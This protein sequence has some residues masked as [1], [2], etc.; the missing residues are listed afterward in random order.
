MPTDKPQIVANDRL[1]DAN[2]HLTLTA[3][4]AQQR[5]EELAQRNEDQNKIVLEKRAM[6]RELV[7]QLTVFE[8]RERKRLAAELHDYLAQMLVLG[9]LKIGQARHKMS[10]IDLLKAPVIEE[11]DDILDK[12][13]VYTRTLI[14]ELSPPVLHEL[15]LPPAL[16]WLAEQMHPHN[17]TV[18]VQC[19]Q[20]TVPLSE[21]QAILLYQ[22]VRELL[23]NV[24]KHAKTSHATVSLVVEGSDQLLLTV[25]DGGCGFNIGSAEAKSAGEHFGLLSVNERMEAMGGWLKVDSV[26]GRGTTIILGLPLKPPSNLENTR[27][28]SALAR[29]EPR[30]T[31]IRKAPG[32]RSVLLADDHALV[33]QG[34]R[35]ILDG[36][37]DFCVIGEAGNGLEAVTM[38]I[39]LKPDVV[40]MDINMPGMDGIQATQQIKAAQPTTV[41]VGLSVNQSTQVIQAMT[42]AGA[43][44]VVSKDAVPEL[45]HK[46]L[47]MT[48]P[49]FIGPSDNPIQSELPYS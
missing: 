14:A 11:L 1:R 29:L 4:E 19:S 7:S 34:L 12:A 47:T 8:Q 40:L 41:V 42:E 16:K 26:P 38:A 44:G 9:R 6:L 15:G 24:A 37:P 43:S 10:S 17:L 27:A 18:E 39:G 46:V 25:Q 20:Q 22:S 3:L 48:P 32:V 13:L 49:L 30:V 31:P 28:A 35:A 45:L 33:R 21:E 2:E 5:A 36:Y 23:I